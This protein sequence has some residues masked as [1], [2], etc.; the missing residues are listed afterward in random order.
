MLTKTSWNTEH[1]IKIKQ[2]NLAQYYNKQLTGIHI[3]MNQGETQKNH[4]RTI[5]HTV[6]SWGCIAQT[7]QQNPSNDEPLT[8]RSNASPHAADDK[9]TDAHFPHTPN[10]KTPS[11]LSPRTDHATKI[12]STPLSL[13]KSTNAERHAH[14]RCHSEISRPEK[15]D[16][17]QT[18]FTKPRIPAAEAKCD[19]YKKLILK[20]T[21]K[22]FPNISS[23]DYP[24]LSLSVFQPPYPSKPL[25]F[26]PPTTPHC[27]P[28]QAP[29]SC[30]IYNTPPLLTYPFFPLLNTLIPLQ[31]HS[32][33]QALLNI[34]SLYV[35]LF[36]FLLLAVLLTLL[37]SHPS[38]LISSTGLPN[39]T[40][41]HQRYPTRT[42]RMVLWFRISENT[43]IAWS[44]IASRRCT[45]WDY[46]PQFW[47]Q[48]RDEYLANLADDVLP[49]LVEN[50][51]GINP[52]LIIT[53]EQRKHVN[54]HHHPRTPPKPASPILNF[55]VNAIFPPLP[56]SITS[57]TSPISSP[58]TDNRSK[59]RFVTD[60]AAVLSLST[61]NCAMNTLATQPS[62]D[63]DNHNN[64]NI[65][66]PFQ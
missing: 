63:A 14:I 18:Q 31:I 11:T 32:P 16:G 61:I 6:P 51:Q 21:I 25:K 3:H 38:S 10:M 15:R 12:V 42:P 8:L 35:N 60:T 28:K 2:T 59:P 39:A 22:M 40:F 47:Q 27:S 34:L 45:R 41:N 4:T 65:N 64:N 20:T 36:R 9:S 26:N 24:A 53:E 23:K 58:R 13:I 62:D 50:R 48:V 33:L 30:S 17:P 37:S 44:K 49:V 55:D 46:Y 7:D 66:P 57:L 5:G 29:T 52:C 54:D 19:G 43:A 1:W 56:P